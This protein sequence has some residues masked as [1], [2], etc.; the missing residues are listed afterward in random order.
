MPYLNV[1][2]NYPEH[3]KVDRLSDGA[4]RLHTS[5]LCHCAR[6][7][8]DGFVEESKVG[9]LMP[10]F[11]PSYIQ[12]L[13]ESHPERPLWAKVQGGYHVHDYLD[14]N[15]SREWWTAKR[16]KDAKRRAEHRA[17]KGQAT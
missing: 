6:Q 13:L 16:E 4:F 1:D 14:W 8:T 3:G 17:S 5:A 12:E 10:K 11:R 15:K 2:D 9:R 7:L